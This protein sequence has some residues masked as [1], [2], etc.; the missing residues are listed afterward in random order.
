MSSG[1]LSNETHAQF[2]QLILNRVNARAHFRQMVHFPL[3][4]V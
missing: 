2:E 3:K 4:C 1:E